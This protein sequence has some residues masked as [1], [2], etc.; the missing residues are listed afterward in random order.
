MSY[1][2]KLDILCYESTELDKTCFISGRSRDQEE[3]GGKRNTVDWLP[4]RWRSCQLFQ[5]G[6]IQYGRH[7]E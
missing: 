5:N 4:T 2:T 6:S 7:K 1:S 3:N